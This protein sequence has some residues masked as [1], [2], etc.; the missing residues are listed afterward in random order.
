MPSRR[1]GFD[2]RQVLWWNEATPSSATDPSRPC[3]VSASTPLCHGGRTGSTPVRGARTGFGSQVSVFKFQV[4]LFNL[5]L[6][7]FETWN[8]AKHG[9][10]T[11]RA[12]KLKPWR[13]WVRLPPVLL[14][15]ASD[16]AGTPGGL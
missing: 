3:G 12:T 1:G 15:N 7:T 11:G 9:T 6:E 10:P 13:V 8:A 5:E 4:G 16:G 14:V 2:S